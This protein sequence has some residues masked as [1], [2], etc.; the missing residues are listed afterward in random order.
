[1]G[2][3]WGRCGSLWGHCGS[4]WIIVGRCG[5]LWVVVGRCGSLWVVVDR[6]GSFHVLVTTNRCQRSRHDILEQALKQALNSIVQNDDSNTDPRRVIKKV[7]MKSLGERD[8]AAQE[9]MHHLLSLKL[10]RSS[11]KVMSVSLNG[12]RRVCDS[13][14]IDEV[15]RAPIIHFLMCMQIVNNMRVHKI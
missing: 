13:A 11:F 14:S 7:V 5:S 6:C 10:H 9:T 4:L 3:L 12:S 2:S 1:M 15:N 8:Y